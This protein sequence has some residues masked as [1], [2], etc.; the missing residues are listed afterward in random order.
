MEI[1]K[2]SQYNESSDSQLE[3]GKK[4]ESEHLDVYEYFQ[5]FLDKHDLKMPLS[6][7]ELYEMIAKAHIKEI[8]DYYDRL[9][10][11]EKEAED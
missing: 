3:I 9:T 2:Y 7:D 4:I 8:P 11:M 6:K 10:K 1:K 5:D